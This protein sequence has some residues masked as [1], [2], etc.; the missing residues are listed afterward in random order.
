MWNSRRAHA[1]DR[2][3]RAL[4]PSVQH[5]TQQSL[6]PVSSPRSHLVVGV[7]RGFLSGYFEQGEAQAEEVPAAETGSRTV[8]VLL[9]GSFTR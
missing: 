8:S 9:L 7:G 6:N 4:A 1:L 2:Y 3:L 5:L